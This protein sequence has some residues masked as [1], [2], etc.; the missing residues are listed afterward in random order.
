MVAFPSSTLTTVREAWKFVVDSSPVEVLMGYYDIV[1]LIV[2]NPF[3]HDRPRNVRNN[4]RP[5]YRQFRVLS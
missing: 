5:C 2:R 1:Y 4:F 3:S